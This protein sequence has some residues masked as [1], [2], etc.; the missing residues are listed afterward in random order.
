MMWLAPAWKVL[1]WTRSYDSENFPAQKARRALSHLLHAK[2]ADM[3]ALRQPRGPKCPP[4][5]GWNNGDESDGAK[6]H[7]ISSNYARPHERPA[8]AC[9]GTVGERSCYFSKRCSW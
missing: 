8:V 9:L 2:A 3:S 6:R 7:D 4:E 1:E 5:R